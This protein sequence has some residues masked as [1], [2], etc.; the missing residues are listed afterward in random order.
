MLA[1][2]ARFLL[3]FDDLCPTVN[4]ER[5]RACAELVAE[6]DL[7][8]ILAVVPDNRDRELEPSPADPEFWA[9]MRAMRAAG[10]AIA[11]H[12]FRHVCASSG[13]GLL[14]LARQSEFAGVDLATQREWIAAGV[15][16]LRGHGLAPRLWVAPRHG[17]DRN[18]LLALKDEGID[19]L[20]DGFARMPFVRDGLIWIPQQLWGPAEKEAGVWTIAIHPN[21]ARDE[22]I[23]ALRAFLRQHA[24]QFTSVDRLLR[25]VPPRR[26]GVREAAYV[27]LALARVRLRNWR[28]R[29]FS[30]S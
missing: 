5:W 15:R 20:S 26:L 10:C 30:A 9:Q 2:P 8:P 28:R 13:R 11:L 19:T 23:Q 1:N 7:K 4:A 12:G 16:I 24:A 27:T 22:Q 6:F 18:T 25:E 3:R 21:T 17:F 14:N 29:T